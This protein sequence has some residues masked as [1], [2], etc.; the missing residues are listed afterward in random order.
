MTPWIIIT[1]DNCS[2]CTHLET[3]LQQQGVCYKTVPVTSVAHLPAAPMI[4]PALFHAEEL[5][6]Y[7]VEDILAYIKKQEAGC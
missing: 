2:A 4:T 1:Q 6:A 5:V 3:H 7:G